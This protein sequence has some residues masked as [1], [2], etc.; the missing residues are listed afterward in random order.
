VG[1]GAPALNA[2]GGTLMGFAPRSR[3][4][5]QHAIVL[6]GIPTLSPHALPAYGARGRCRGRSDDAV[7]F[8]IESR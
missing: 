5:R 3:A 7:G 4:R 1:P 6:Y 8:G 2:G